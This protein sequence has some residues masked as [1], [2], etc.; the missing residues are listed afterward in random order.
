MARDANGG[1][2]M[3]IKGK[4]AALFILSVASY[5]AFSGVAHA[6]GLVYF[7]ITPGGNWNQ[8]ST[9]SVG[10]SVPGAADIAAINDGFPVVITD[11]QSASQLV[12]ADAVSIGGDLTVGVLLTV[13]SGGLGTVVTTSGATLT[14][15]GMNVGAASTGTYVHDG[16][17]P[18]TS[19]VLIGSLGVGSIASGEFEIRGSNGPILATSA[20]VIFGIASTLRI[21]PTAN[22]GAGLV[23]ITGG[24]VFLQPGSTLVL[25]DSLH[26][27]RVGDSWTVITGASSITGSFTNLLAPAGVTIS[28][29]VAKAVGTVTITVT[30]APAPAL[31]ATSYW[32]LAILVSLLIVTGLFYVAHRRRS[33]IAID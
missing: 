23:P 10:G 6:G 1:I 2:G 12:A 15:G 7:S 29:V 3:T 4:Y 16:V 30:A 18:S 26:T 33:A 21:T 32:G 27:P 13:G 5:V 25:D 24:T 9:W 19:T 14:T 20:S 17:V 31:P 22:G 8:N 28:Q 11:T